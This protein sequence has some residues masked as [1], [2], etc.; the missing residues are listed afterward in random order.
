MP[1]LQRD[2]RDP[3]HNVVRGVPVVQRDRAEAEKAQAVS[4]PAPRRPWK[5]EP[6][7]IALLAALLAL[8]ILGHAAVAIVGALPPRIEYVGQDRVM[9]QGFAVEW[10]VTMRI[11]GEPITATFYSEKEQVR[12]LDELEGTR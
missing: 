4:S 11:A 1:T 3:G 2:R 12:L 5:R 10:T 7:V 9:L 8:V 6:A